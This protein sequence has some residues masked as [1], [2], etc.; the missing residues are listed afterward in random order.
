MA[1]AAGTISVAVVAVASLSGCTFVGLLAQGPKSNPDSSS[2]SSTTTS[3]PEETVEPLDEIASPTPTQSS[4][5]SSGDRKVSVETL[6]TGD[7]FSVPDMNASSVAE[8]TKHSSCSAPHDFEVISVHHMTETSFPG[9]SAVEKRAHEQCPKD[10]STYSANP[11]E[12]S[13]T[14][15]GPSAQTWGAGDRE[16]MCIAGVDGAKSSKSAKR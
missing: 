5:T 3:S 12:W 13:V 6:H 16:L 1:R 8:V 14:Y 9:S 10:L 11:S 15:L 7:C 4:R 2:H